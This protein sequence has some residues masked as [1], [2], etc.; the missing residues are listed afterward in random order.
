MEAFHSQLTALES[1]NTELTE[2]ISFLNQQQVSF[3]KNLSFMMNSELLSQQQN[4]AKAS[5]SVTGTESRTTGGAGSRQ[6]MLQLLATLNDDLTSLQSQ[7]VSLSGL[8]IAQTAP[9]LLSASATD[10]TQDFSVL[11]TLR[12][13]RQAIQWIDE[14]TKELGQ[15]LA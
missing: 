4:S 11:D 6:D 3:E 10:T 12:A 2:H 15:K 8:A 5:D 14:K 7:L 13:N 1:A 9:Q